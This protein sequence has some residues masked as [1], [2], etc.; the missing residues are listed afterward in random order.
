[1]LDLTN[2][3][4]IVY[5]K[6]TIIQH[7]MLELGISGYMA[8]F[9]EYL[10][11]DAV[12][13]DGDPAE[14]HNK[15]PV[16]WA[17]ANREAVAEAG[18]ETEVMF[19]TRSGYSGCE[20][21]APIMWNG[22]QYTDYSVDY[23]MP[24]VMPATFNLGFSGVSAAHCDI[25]GFI[26]FG[27]LARDAE[28]FVRWMELSAFSPLM[29]S[30]ES[31]RPENNAQ[32][33]SPGV[34]RHT[35]ALTTVHQNLKPYISHCLEKA[36][37]GIPVMAPDFYYSSDYSRHRDVYSYCFGDE[38]FVS[39]VIKKGV[40]QK[41]VYLPAGEWVHFVTR[42]TYTAGEITVDAPLGCP[43]AFYRKNGAFSTLFES[44]L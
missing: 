27:S 32:Y 11:V 44:V 34:I 37:K 21:Y 12:L 29:R 3:G 28:L 25:G 38:V 16:L 7:N 22:D 33:D 40:A 2:P 36:R 23:G 5:L 17:Q 9:G 19:F 41:T 10:P 43:P 14:L 30:H 1:M 15:W 13:C 24:C 6:E 20:R 31:I 18:M 42:K 4:A 8:D 35:V 39:P 26:S